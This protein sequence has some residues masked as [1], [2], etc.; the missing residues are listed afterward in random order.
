MTEQAPRTT[1]QRKKRRRRDPCEAQ[2]LFDSGLSWEE[3]AHKLRYASADSA[4]LSARGWLA[5]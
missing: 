4:R 5:R 2:R 3:V 1:K